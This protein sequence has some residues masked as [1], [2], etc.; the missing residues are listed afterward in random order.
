MH[1]YSILLIGLFCFPYEEAGD[2]H[3]NQLSQTIRTKYELPKLFE[4]I[5]SKQN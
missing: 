3:I 2:R 4:D 5:Y 1:I